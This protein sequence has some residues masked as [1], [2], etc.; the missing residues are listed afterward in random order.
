[1]P[2]KYAIRITEANLGL[3]K[4]LHPIVDV[5]LKLTDTN[6]YFYFDIDGPMTTTNHDIMDGDSLRNENDVINGERIVIE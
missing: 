3:I 4:L 6:R 5:Q 1:M 2:N